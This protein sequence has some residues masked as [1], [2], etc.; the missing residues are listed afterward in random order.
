[1]SDIKF[2]CPSCQQHIQCEQGYAGME[3]ACPSCHAKMVVPGSISAPAPAPAPGLRMSAS[4][5]PPP[6][7]PPPAPAATGRTC[8]SC[9]N[10]VAPAA[11]MCIKCGTNLRTGQK[12]TAPGRPGARVSAPAGAAGPW[13]KTP[14]PYLGGYLVILAVLY[15]LGQSSPDMKLLFLLGLGLYLIG[16]H[17]IVTVFAFIDDGAFKGFLCLCIGIYTIYYVLKESQRGYLKVMYAIAFVI[18]L[19]VKFDVIN[20]GPVDK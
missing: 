18:G 10:P 9:G 2:S 4:A 13:Y 12:M 11:I 3:I 16:S 20:F 5:P 17:I 7:T 1:M 15:F 8:P 14:Y 6:P 19:L